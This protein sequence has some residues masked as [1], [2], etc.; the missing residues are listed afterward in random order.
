MGRAE[1]GVEKNTE[2]S[3]P[4]LHT[5]TFWIS[6]SHSNS[7]LT[8]LYRSSLLIL[9]RSPPASHKHRNA[10]SEN[11]MNRAGTQPLDRFGTAGGSLGSSPLWEGDKTSCQT[12]R[13]SFTPLYHCQKSI[14]GSPRTLGKL[15]FLYFRES[16][17]QMLTIFLSVSPPDPR[18]DTKA[19]HTGIVGFVVTDRSGLVRLPDSVPVDTRQRRWKRCMTRLTLAS[20]DQR[21]WRGQDRAQEQ[22]L[23]RDPT[24]ELVAHRWKLVDPPLS[25]EEE[26]LH[27]LSVRSATAN[28]Q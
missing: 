28:K 24:C 7:M 13:V 11:E 25:L 5:L 8:K 2:P 21:R 27:D 22:S 23:A 18:C 10:G 12:I 14:L 4:T 26:A 17:P 20:H 19:S 1:E 6:P 16:V 3:A 9:F 15:L